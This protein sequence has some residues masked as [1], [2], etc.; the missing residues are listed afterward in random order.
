MNPIHH[1]LIRNLLLP[2]LSGLLLLVCYPPFSLSFVAF[3]AWMPLLIS[4][5]GKDFRRAF[6]SGWI[7]GVIFY[8][9][10]IYWLAYVTLE[11]YAL[12][13]LYLSLF[14]AL[15]CGVISRFRGP[16]ARPLWGALIWTLME[17]LRSVGEWSF[18]WGLLAHSQWTTPQLMHSVRWVGVYGLSFLLMAC[19]LSLVEIWLARRKGRLVRN[20]WFWPF[21][22]A[23]ALAI[24]GQGQGRLVRPAT[25]MPLRVSLIQGNYPQGEKWDH[26][27]QDVLEAYLALSEQALIA[28]SPDLI[29]WPETAIPDILTRR[30]DIRVQIEDW[31]EMHRVPLL[32]GTIMEK[33][34]A[35]YSMPI[36]NSACY[37]HPSPREGVLWQ[38]YNK[39]HLVP[40]GE[41][42]PFQRLFPFLKRMVEARGGGEYEPGDSFP[43][44]EVKGLRFGALICFE[45]TLPSLAR[46]Y[47]L[48]NVDFLVVITND[49]WFERSSA[50]FQH[51][52]QSAFRAVE[53]GVPVVRATNTG[54][55]SAFD[56]R[57]RLIASM[58]IYE[59]GYLTVEIHP[60]RSRT[61]YVR[62]GD[63]PVLIALGLFIGYATVFFLFPSHLP[64]RRSSFTPVLKK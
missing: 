55:T 31:V 4:L 23:I 48:Q 28:D 57:G 40:Y 5:E 59:G 24:I 46:K 19:N 53:N 25:P 51:A 54:W 64:G 11:G 52:L 42:V 9:F 30:N 20:S 13:V 44:F 63:L 17:Y 2:A 60:G 3:F 61:L 15:F 38:Q 12:V 39:V 34:A 8:S 58:P 22:L 41:R 14:P 6:Q 47:G 37:V 49:A 50:P 1:R 56:S 26:S 33:D 45:S 35:D 43:V 27:V 32:F 21:G 18:S 36:Y 16:V 7:A 29:V 10:L 62:M